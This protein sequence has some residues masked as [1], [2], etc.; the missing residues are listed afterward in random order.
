MQPEVASNFFNQKWNK[1][2]TG[3]WIIKVTTLLESLSMLKKMHK[4]RRTGDSIQTKPTTFAKLISKT[5]FNTNSYFYCGLDTTGG[6][7]RYLI[8]YVFPSRKK[9]F[10]PLDKQILW[11]W[12]EKSAKRSLRSIGRIGRD[13]ET[14]LW[15][16]Q[17][18]IHFTERKFWYTSR[19]TY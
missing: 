6:I 3:Y 17:K 13:A 10:K 9:L 19:I 15:D 1:P 12:V 8:L 4:K 11:E 2:L 14:E 18:A 16:C 7:L 5:C